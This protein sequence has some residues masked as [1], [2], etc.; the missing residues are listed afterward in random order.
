MSYTQSTETALDDIAEDSNEI[1]TALR[2]GTHAAGHHTIT[3]GAVHTHVTLDEDGKPHTTTVDHRHLK[4]TPDRFRGTTYVHSI[5]AFVDLA[6]HYYGDDIE[7]AGA[8]TYADHKAR[9]LT[10]ILNDQYYEH[11]TQWADQRIVHKIERT[12]EWQRWIEIDRTMLSQEEAAE[13]IEDRLIDIKDP[14]GNVLLDIAQTMSAKGT[15]ELRNARR[16]QNGAVQVVYAEDIETTSGDQHMEI[17]GRIVLSLPISHGAADTEISVR[18]RYRWHRPNLT[19]AFLL[20]NVAHR[21][22]RQDPP[23]C[24]MDRDRRRGANGSARPDPHDRMTEAFVGAATT[25]SVVVAALAIY[26]LIHYWWADR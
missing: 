19:M 8:V 14:A 22:H 10:T 25:A 18:F 3:T 4:D 12:P 15:V 21:H 17:P 7:L 23:R 13:F 16:L 26:V 1:A 24:P 20:D 5:E 6:G 11:D 2:F 9:T